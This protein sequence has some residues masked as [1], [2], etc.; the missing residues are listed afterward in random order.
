MR[1]LHQARSAGKTQSG[2]ASH[3]ATSLTQAKSLAT[4]MLGPKQPSAQSML[5]GMG[6]DLHC[7]ANGVICVCPTM[8]INSGKDRAELA[9]STGRDFTS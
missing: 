3:H 2:R 6:S 8:R 1:A 7:Q 9:C 5:A 4:A